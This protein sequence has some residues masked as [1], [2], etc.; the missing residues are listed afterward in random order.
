MLDD[1]QDVKEVSLRPKRIYDLIKF[2]IDVNIDIYCDI[3]TVIWN[4]HYPGIYG[5]LKEKIKK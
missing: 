3:V 2:C 4:R 5:K 1:T